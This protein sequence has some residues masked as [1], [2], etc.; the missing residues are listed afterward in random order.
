[1]DAICSLKSEILFLSDI[2]MGQISNQQSTLKVSSTFNRSRLRD[3][4]FLSNS[5]DNK[6]GVAILISKKLNPEV[7]DT[8]RD[9]NQNILLVECNINGNR[10]ILGSIY[11]PNSTCRQFYRDITSFLERKINVPVILGGDW[12]V[13]WS[14]SG[15]EDN[16]DISGMVRTPNFTNGNLLKNL[17]NDFELTD[18]F[19]ILYPDRKCYSYVPFGNARKNKSRLDFFI[20]STSLLGA[21]VDCGIFPGMLSSQ[22][23]HKP[24]F[25]HF[26]SEKTFKKDKSLKNWFLEEEE[27]KIST[28]LAALQIYIRSIDRAENPV[29]H[30]QLITAVNSINVIMLRVLELR[31]QIAKNYNGNMDFENLLLSALYAE[32]REIMDGLPEFLVINA[33]KRVCS[34]K[35]FFMDLTSH[36]SLR[37]SGVQRKLNKLKNLKKNLLIKEINELNSVANPDAG[38]LDTCE[39]ELNSILNLELRRLISKKKIFEGLTNEKPTKRFF[40]VAH[41][42]G[43]GDKLTNILN[44]DGNPF[45]NSDELGNH[46]TN[47]YSSLYRKDQDV[48]GEIEEFLGEDICNHPAV[49]NSRLSDTQRA[50]LD[51]DL[52]FEEIE[53]ALNESNMKSA[54]GIDGFSNVFIKN[55]FIYWEGRYM[56]A[57]CNVS[58]ISH[59]LKLF[60]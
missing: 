27:V 54:P 2:R 5:T 56:T 13:T 11:G 19:R 3:H 33:A 50:E 43:K 37:V 48:G 26:N 4:I 32:H 17:A 28:E 21:V 35:E 57:A 36:V 52:T 58:R 22:F 24:I 40:E 30:E 41:N 1:M 46:I 44:E 10:L 38:R 20:I 25:L 31:E 53:T 59:L 55:F 45:A 6:R 23:D 8:F 42:V 18:P 12:N 7:L 34:N 47:F 49:R 16:I 39:R 60:R 51:S 14:N 15:P 9:Q 29:L